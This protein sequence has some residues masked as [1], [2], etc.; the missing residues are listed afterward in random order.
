MYGDAIMAD[1][2]LAALREAAEQATGW[3]HQRD[4]LIH[5]ARHAGATWP[6]IAAAAS[7]SRT[8]VIDIYRRIQATRREKPDRGQTGRT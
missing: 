3:T 4:Q 6:T 7:L 2:P 5:D 8:G 1:D